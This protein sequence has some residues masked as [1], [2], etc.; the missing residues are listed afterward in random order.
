MNR[1]RNYRF[2]ILC[3]AALLLSGACTAY[4][5]PLRRIY[6]YSEKAVGENEFVVKYAG[7]PYGISVERARSYTLY[8]CAEITVEKGFDYFEIIPH[9]HD[10]FIDG[11][12]VFGIPTITRRIRLHKGE[13]PEDKP[14]A[15][16]ARELLEILGPQIIRKPER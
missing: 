7:N 6:G 16:D 13:V 15:R 4:Y 1:S 9:P 10:R 12:E 2:W 3:L 5:Q 14:L 8:R 11:P